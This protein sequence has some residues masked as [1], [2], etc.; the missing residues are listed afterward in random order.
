MHFVTF[1]IFYER[2]PMK[3]TSKEGKK[4][5]GQ[6]GEVHYLNKLQRGSLQV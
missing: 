5:E 6:T 3:E 2:G 1:V 4:K